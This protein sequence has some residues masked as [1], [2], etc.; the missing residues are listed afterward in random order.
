MK[1]NERLDFEKLIILNLNENA[2]QF[3]FI[4][5]FCL[6]QQV[7]FFSKMK[8]QWYKYREKT[9]TNKIILFVIL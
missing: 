7:R 9:S 5:Q 4:I 1:N 8:W 6:G 3:S 2:M